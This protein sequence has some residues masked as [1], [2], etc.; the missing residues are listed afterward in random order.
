MLNNP[1]C[2]GLVKNPVDYIYSITLVVATFR[3][4]FMI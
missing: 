3:S 1:L 4:L 2:N